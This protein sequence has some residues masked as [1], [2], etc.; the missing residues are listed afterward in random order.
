M[1]TSNGQGSSDSRQY[2]LSILAQNPQVN[3]DQWLPI[4]AKCFIESEERHEK[5][6]NRLFGDETLHQTGLVQEI[7]QSNAK[8]QKE[9]S[10][11]DKKI[12]NLDV[13]INPV[14]TFHKNAIKLTAILG[15]PI[16]VG[17]G[18]IG[19]WLKE[20]FKMQ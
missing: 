1:S 20:H 9:I 15:G 17:L 6:H 19:A 12:G 8:L 2:L 14:V 18:W 5:L 11:L 7:K 16:M 3:Q 10:D 13:K 4:L